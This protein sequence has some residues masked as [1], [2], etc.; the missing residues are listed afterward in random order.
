LTLRVRVEQKLSEIA[1]PGTV[2]LVKSKNRLPVS[3]Q[4][5]AFV[6]AHAELIV[7][8]APQNMQTQPVIALLKAVNEGDRKQLKS[9]FS[10]RVRAQYEKEGWSRALQQ[11][12]NFCKEAFGEYTMD[13]FTFEYKGDKEKGEVSVIHKGKTFTSLLVVTENAEWK[14]DER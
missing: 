7:A 2:S 9:A 6:D 1:S 11:Y 10:E 13:D 4:A 12:Q 8:E 5:V 3:K 14:I